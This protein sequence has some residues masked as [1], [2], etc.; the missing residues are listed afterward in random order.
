MRKLPLLAGVLSVVLIGTAIALAVAAR[1]ES[2]SK[3][4]RQA[5]VS[6]TQGASTSSTKFVRL[7]SL[8][9]LRLSNN[10]RG[11]SATMSGTFSGAPV[12]VRVRVGENGVILAPGAVPFRATGRDSF[13]HVFVRG[14]PAPCVLLN[15]E[16][17]S[18]NG[19]EAQFHGGVL[20]ALFKPLRPPKTCG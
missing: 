8:G 2:S 20:Q 14:R 16:W 6:S 18:L 15:V 1:Q 5:F 11:I 4:G 10:R 13:S 19:E 12:A 17:R 7:K 9:P 3:V